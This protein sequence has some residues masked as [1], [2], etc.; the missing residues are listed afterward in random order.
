MSS[1]FPYFTP[2]W[3][4]VLVTVLLVFITGALAFYTGKLYKATVKLGRDAEESG[5]TQSDKMEKSILEATRAA[6]A[7]ERVAE[8]ASISASAATQSVAALR[9]KQMRAY[10]TVLIG[11]GTYQQRTSFWQRQTLKFDV[12]PI[13]VNSGH[14]PAHKINY[15]AKAAILDF[16]LPN[17]FVFTEPENT[18]KSS[19]FIGAQ[20][21]LELNAMVDDFVPDE[22]VENIKIGNSKRVYIWGIV[23]YIDVFDEVHTTKFCHSIFWFGPKNNERVTGTFSNLHNEAT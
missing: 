18:I 4:M 9:A 23:T 2:E 22:E 11:S 7:M 13:L 10:L 1:Q 6:T 3:A 16:P 12:R 14:T 17:D 15:W 5:K 8:S 19:M 21:S 20:Q